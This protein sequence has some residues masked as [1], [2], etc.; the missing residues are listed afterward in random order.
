[1]AVAAVLV[2]VAAI[3]AP[4]AS[5]GPVASAAGFR[6]CSVPPDTFFTSIRARGVICSKAVKVLTQGECADDP[7]SITTLGPW[8]CKTKG[9]IA[10]RTTRCEAPP[11]AAGGKPRRVI[12]TASGD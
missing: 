8:R 12:A 1:M 5:A 9:G 4:Q 7:C 10:S 11:K 2:A 6:E 3:A